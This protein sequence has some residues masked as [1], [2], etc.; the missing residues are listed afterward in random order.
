MKTRLLLLGVLALVCSCKESRFQPASEASRVRQTS[1]PAVPEESP[2][3]VRNEEKPELPPNERTRPSQPPVERDYPKPEIPVA[4]A[5]EGKP[6]FV[7]SPFNGKI[8][9]VRDIPPGTLVA[10]PTAPSEEKKH[11]RVP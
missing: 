3:E 2:V 5:V 7:L 9:D 8:I 4:Q 11:F 1:S 10:D 6:G